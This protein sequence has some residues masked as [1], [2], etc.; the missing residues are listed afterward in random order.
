[1]IMFMGFWLFEESVVQIVTI[2]FSSLIILEL[3]N[4]YTEL[5]SFSL[6]VFV[7]QILTFAI[8]ILSIVFLKDQIDVAAIDAKFIERVGIIVALTWGPFQIMMYLRKKLDPTEN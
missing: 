5:T 1:M 6:I 8:Y 3:L 4:I 7:S 2:T